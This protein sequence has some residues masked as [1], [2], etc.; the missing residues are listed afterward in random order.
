MLG[1]S[2][3]NLFTRIFVYGFLVHYL[4]RCPLI[5]ALEID[6]YNPHITLKCRLL[7]D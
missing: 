1:D 6:L 7:W 3:L 2:D 5:N 4:G